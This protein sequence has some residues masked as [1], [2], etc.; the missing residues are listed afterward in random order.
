[1]ARGQRGEGNTRRGLCPNKLAE[2]LLWSLERTHSLVTRPQS[3][4]LHLVCWRSLSCLDSSVELKRRGAYRVTQGRCITKRF[5]PD[6]PTPLTYACKQLR[7]HL[8]DLPSHLFITPSVSLFGQKIAS[9]DFDGLCILRP[10]GGGGGPRRRARHV[11]THK[12]TR[13]RAPAHLHQGQFISSS[14]SR[15]PLISSPAAPISCGDRKAVTH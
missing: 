7:G 12:R 4:P 9:E 3:C 6:P 15:R 5:P 13:S 1:M 8:P 2:T 10:R 11:C 14:T